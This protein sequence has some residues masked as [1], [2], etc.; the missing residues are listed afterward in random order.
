MICWNAI[1]IYSYYQFKKGEKILNYKRYKQ[2]RRPINSSVFS[3]IKNFTVPS[4]K[5]VRVTNFFKPLKNNLDMFFT[6]FSVHMLHFKIV[7][8][9]Y[10]FEHTNSSHMYMLI[11]NEVPE[12]RYSCHRYLIQFVCGKIL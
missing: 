1:N 9:T 12:S 3:K 7:M 10:N 5:K 11:P 4:L 8:L 2:K 6:V